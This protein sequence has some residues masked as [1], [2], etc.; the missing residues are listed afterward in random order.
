MIDGSAIAAKIIADLKK[1]KT[2]T[3]TLAAILVG[4]DKASLSFLKQKEKTAK[5]LG[6]RFVLH[7]LPE[8]LSQLELEGHVRAISN[9]KT[10]GAV[11]VQLP[12]PKKYDRI[13]VLNA[14]GIEK[15]VD[16]LNGET[17]KVLPPAVGALKHILEESKI[18]LTGKK[19]VVIGPGMLIGRPVAGW[20]MDRV[21]KLTVLGKAKLDVEVVKEADLVVSGTGVPHLLD[22]KHIKPKAVVIDF[23]YGQLEGKT[24][25]DV[26]AK[27]IAIK[28]KLVTPTPGGTGPVV[29][30]MLFE[31][32]FKI[33][34]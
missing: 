11:I 32:F 34:D 7:I 8:S 12:L 4:D 30:A 21:V 28:T 18:S 24:V 26:D 29:V 19:A 31:N 6:V 20:L 16:V 27:S 25:G 10:V 17:T 5:E 2:P 33:S 14:I 13:P 22:E 3:K 1:K 23:G 15:D 9:D